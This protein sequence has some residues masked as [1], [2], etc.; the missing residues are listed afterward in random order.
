MCLAAKRAF[1]TTRASRLVVNAPL[2]AHEGRREVRGA[3]REVRDARCEMREALVLGERGK[4]IPDKE[5]Q[6]K[7]KRTRRKGANTH[8]H[9]HI[10]CAKSVQSSL[11]VC[12]SVKRKGKIIVTMHVQVHASQM[13]YM[14]WYLL[15]C[16]QVVPYSVP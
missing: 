5:R 2:E 9:T 16:L 6:K 15:Y 7:R 14:P 1:S 13:H 4:R 11:S 8:T 3:R 10:N 12:P